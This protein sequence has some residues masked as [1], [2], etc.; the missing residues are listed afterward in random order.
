MKFRLIILLNLLIFEVVAQK[1]EIISDRPFQ[2]I[3]SAVISARTFQIESGFEYA[4]ARAGRVKSE[5]ISYNNS[6]LRVGLFENVE[7]R[8]G[9]AYESVEV[10]SDINPVNIE[11]W[12]PLVVGGK[13]NI[14]KESRWKPEIAVLGHLTLPIL[15]NESF[16][17]ESVAPDFRLTFS[18]S[19]RPKFSLKY[20]L[21]LEWP[22]NNTKD[23]LEIYSI[24]LSYKIFNRFSCFVEHYGVVDTLFG[25]NGGFIWL[26]KTNFQIDLYGGTGLNQESQD[27]IIGLGVTWRIP[28]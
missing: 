18:H 24:F 5:Y 7:L 17:P 8:F 25:I 13:I 28:R 23:V 12:K 11:G 20:N 21:G 10:K 19:L 3:S 27:L 22:M 14:L 9:I 26:L 2:T 4:Q 6:M 1:T 16:K 15:G